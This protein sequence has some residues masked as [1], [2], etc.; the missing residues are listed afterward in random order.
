VKF[1]GNMGISPVTIR[2]LQM[3]GHDAKRLLE[4]GL[5]RL[6]DPDILEKAR[7]EQ[8]ILL[9]SDLDFGALVAASHTQL[10]SVIIFRLNDMRPVNV[11]RY[12]VRILADHA[13]DLE[14][15]AILSVSEGRIRV[16]HL[17]L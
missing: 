10:P 11:N 3:Q 5:E 16:R 15:G 8:C 7:A 13:A 6:P 4:E 14:R 2:F 9:T 17:P 1:L 12:L